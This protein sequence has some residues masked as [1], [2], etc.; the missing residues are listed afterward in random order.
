M[1]RFDFGDTIYCNSLA[2]ESD[3]T[4][5]RLEGEARISFPNRRLRME[6]L[7]DPGEGQRSNFVLWCPETFP[8]DVSIEWEFW[9]VQ[10]PGLCILFFAATG[11]NGEDLFDSSLVE[12]TGE[13]LQYH[14]GDIDALHVSYFRRRWPEE[15]AFH[16]CNLR[17]SYGFHMVAQGADPIPPVEDATPPYRIQVVKCGDEVSFSINELPIFDW[18]DDGVR[19]GPVLG[20]GKIGLRQMAPLVGEYANLVMRRVSQEGE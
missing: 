14:H 19:Y 8:A 1:R 20:G 5:F 12:R 4:G 16:T 3:V 10:E 6:N 11:R 2:S 7:R 18:R 9:P 17:K 15:R 13:Y